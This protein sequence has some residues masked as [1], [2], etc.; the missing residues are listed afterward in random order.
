MIEWLI[1]FLVAK[2]WMD[3]DEKKKQAFS[4]NIDCNA[5]QFGYLKNGESLEDLK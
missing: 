2:W 3:K 5:E 4:G 1:G